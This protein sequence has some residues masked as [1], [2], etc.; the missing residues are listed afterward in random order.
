M[1][2]IISFCINAWSKPDTLFREGKVWMKE[3]W[4]QDGKVNGSKSNLNKTLNESFAWARTVGFSL[5]RINKVHQVSS[6]FWLPEACLDCVQ[7]YILNHSRLKK[8]V[9]EMMCTVSYC[10]FCTYMYVDRYS[11]NSTKKMRGK[12]TELF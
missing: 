12:S 8:W 3:P 1:Y 6:L 9:Q 4:I 5:K 2:S 7:I 11:N 10:L